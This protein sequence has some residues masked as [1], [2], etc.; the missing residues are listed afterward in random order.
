V[1]QPCNLA[2]HV[3]YEAGV[4]IDPTEDNR[5][6]SSKDTLVHRDPTTDRWGL[7]DVQTSN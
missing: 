6:V 2:C 3:R 7:R 1:T 4:L 5:G